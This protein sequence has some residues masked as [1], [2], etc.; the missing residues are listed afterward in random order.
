MKWRLL[1]SATEV[2]I[3]AGG[4]HTA[5]IASFQGNDG[6]KDIL[7]AHLVKDG[8]CLCLLTEFEKA[9]GEHAFS[10]TTQWPLDIVARLP[11][12]FEREE[13]EA[14]ARFLAEW[15]VVTPTPVPPLEELEEDLDLGGKHPPQPHDQDNSLQ[16]P[17]P[18]VTLEQ[19]P[20]T[21]PENTPENTPEPVAT[22]HALSRHEAMARADEPSTP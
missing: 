22:D 21:T 7:K 4:E 9:D 15:P 17:E 6:F 13:D 8:D 19:P 5:P 1:E 3:T 16:Q 2:V 20:V 18:P 11:I 10:R 12:I 14:R